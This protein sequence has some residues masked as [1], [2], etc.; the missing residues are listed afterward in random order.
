[1]STSTDQQD[2]TVLITGFTPDSKNSIVHEALRVGDR[3]VAV[4]ST[5]GK[6]M[7]PVSNVEGLVSACTT[8][9]PGQPIK[10]RFERI[11]NVGEYQ[12]TGTTD[13]SEN[14]KQTATIAS[15][16]AEASL[17]G[18]V[19]GFRN[20]K[21]VTTTA[22]AKGAPV[23]IESTGSNTHKILLSRSRDL[24]RRYKLEKNT[25]TENRSAL[26]KLPAVVADRVLEALAEASAPL[27]SKTLSLV[28][29]SYINCR[30]PDK[31]IRAFEAAVGI[32]GDGS[33]T[34]PEN[35]INSKKGSIS[36]VQ[37]LNALD[38]YTATSLLQAHALNGNYRA[39]QRVLAAMEGRAGTN[40]GNVVSIS[41][42][43]KEKTDVR[44]YNIAL[45]AAAKAGGKKGINTAIE[46][47]ENM[48]S[49]SK[50]LNKDGKMGAVTR[51]LVT[52]NTMIGA[53]AKQSASQDALTIFYSMKDVGVR[54]DK[55]TYTSLL[56]AL[57]EDGDI[58]GGRELLQ[59]MKE[60]G[61]E[62]DVVTYNTMIKALCDNLQWFNAKELVTEME[63]NGVTPNSITYGLLMNGLM[64]ADK[65]STCLTL[66]EAACADE[67]TS[68]LM[69]NVQLYTTAITAASKIG[70]FERSVELVARM[71]K[72][73]VKPNLKTLT[74]LMSACISANEIDQALEV[75]NQ[76]VKVSKSSDSF[77]LD[78]FILTLA[79]RA[80]CEKG[81]FASAAEIMT[82]QKDGYTEMSGRDIMYGYNYFIESSL[83]QE[84]FDVARG[85]LVSSVC[86]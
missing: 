47:F 67:R 30:M 80:Y 14:V 54:P 24:L 5:V 21:E 82:A 19:D 18:A 72:A 37:D 28:M 60:V 41:W 56:K 74:S 10:L 49:P 48:E 66:F 62:I 40:V 11:V 45:A 59:E 38:L 46:I 17:V 4:D 42:P 76:A 68:T 33:V 16:Q 26:R 52:Y 13:A 31:A 32:A 53:L 70:N 58:N 84:K 51:N 15:N 69:E 44:C 43:L 81:D 75:Y 55:Y 64:K 2:G 6:K 27:D 12:S 1:M 71:K 77:N 57:V 73:G 36:L 86:S 63:I 61:V 25:T 29:N 50:L 39:A 78:G 85:A 9:L 22:V 35:K 34:I 65:P 7:W 8:R 79:I 20:L 23:S 3:I 83:K